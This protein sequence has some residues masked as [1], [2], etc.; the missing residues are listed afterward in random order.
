MFVTKFTCG[1]NGNNMPI[2]LEISN[3]SSYRFVRFKNVKAS[4][5]GEQYNEK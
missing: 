2:L 5:N 3:A 4:P 1:A